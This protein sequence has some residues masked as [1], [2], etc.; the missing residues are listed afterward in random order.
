MYFSKSGPSHTHTQKKE[1]GAMLGIQREE[2]N[3]GDKELRSQKRNSEGG[4]ITNR[5]TPQNPP[6]IPRTG[7]T[8]DREDV[9]RI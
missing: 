2:I 8:K 6:H 9:I 7:E 4:Q 3:T 1:T 5:K